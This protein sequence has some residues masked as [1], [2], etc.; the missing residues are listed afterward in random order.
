MVTLD[1]LRRR[2]TASYDRP[3]SPSWPDPHE[4]GSGPH[5][6]EYSRVTD[7]AGYRVVHARAHVWA[8]R[9]GELP[10][11]DVEPLGPVD[12]GSGRFTRGTRI[13]SDQPGTLPLLLLERDVPMSERDIPLAV[14]HLGLARP[15]LTLTALPACGC[16]ACD[17]GSA[18]LLAEID[19]TIGTV[20][21]GPLVLLRGAD[22]HARW[23]PGGQ[24][25][26]GAGTAPEHDSLMALCRGLAA[27]ENVRL[28]LGAEAF[29]SRAWL[30]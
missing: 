10:G 5:H 1:E 18:A 21:D 23:H 29:V 6:D 22:W 2:V 24:S 11:I 14:L 15:D 16:D 26:G 17:D 12:A 7:P 25:S 8:L 3:G 28:P 19:D 27:D 9:L 30:G 4:D 20:L 13:T